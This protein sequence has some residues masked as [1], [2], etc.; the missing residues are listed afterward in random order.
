MNINQW[1]SINLVNF[2]ALTIVV[3]GSIEVQSVELKVLMLKDGS[4]PYAENAG[5]DVLSTFNKAVL[6]Q[7]LLTTETFELQA[8]LLKDWKWSP[9]EGGYSLYLREGLMFHDGTPV[10]SADLEFALLRG[11]FSNQRSFYEIYLG[12]ILGVDKIKPGTKFNSGLVEG[13][14]I[15]GPLSVS[16]KLKNPNP[17]FLYSLTRPYFSFSKKS[18][19][20]DDLITWKKWPIGAGAY[21]VAEEDDEK[22]ILKK[23]HKD[24][25]GAEK[26]K[27]YKKENPNVKYDVSF[28]PTQNMDLYDTKNPSAIYTLFFT[29]QN[30]LSTLSNFRKALKYGIDKNALIAG[31]KFSKAAYE[32]LPSSFWRNDSIE[33]KYDIEKAKQYFEKVPELL[34]KKTWKVPVYSF[35]ELSDNAKRVTGRL[36]EQF[37]KFGFKVE[38]YP[39]PEKFLS[40]ETAKSSPMAYSGRVCNNV[41]PLLMFSSFKTK[42]PYKYDNSQ[43]DSKFDDLFEIASNAVSTEDRVAT[44]RK[45]SRYTIEHDFM[46]PLYENNQTYFYNKNSV[47]SFGYQPNAITLY[48]EEIETK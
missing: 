14:K 42:S 40:L 12:N 37:S 17:S 2:F 5:G 21:E 16:V 31:D 6:G 26:I 33:V 47:K 38:F 19:L 44:M 3:F 23:T 34:R 1:I 18:A 30:E 7:L 9:K 8:G 43:L 15:T 45:L 32:F 22:I 10:T 35:G 27:L 20:N 11:F 28:I 4:R 29:N 48:L 36:R 46:L 24:V 13:V 39:S 25:K 41:D